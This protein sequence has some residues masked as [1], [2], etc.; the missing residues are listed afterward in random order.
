MPLRAKTAAWIFFSRLVPVDSGDLVLPVA[1]LSRDLPGAVSGSC[2]RRGPTIQ[3]EFKQVTMSGNAKQ[4]KE[5]VF[6]L[7]GP[8]SGKGTQVWGQHYRP[9]AIIIVYYCTALL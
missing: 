4:R 5:V 8:G 9:T 3:R 7:G 6:V 1:L 2:V